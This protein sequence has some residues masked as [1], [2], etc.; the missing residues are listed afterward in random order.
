MGVAFDLEALLE[1][2]LQLP[3]QQKLELMAYLMISMGLVAFT[4]LM[5]LSAPYGRYAPANTWLWGPNINGKVAWVLQEAPCLVMTIYCLLHADPSLMA[6]WPNR[7]LVGL[8]AIHYINRTLIFPMRIKGGKPTPLSV[9]LLAFIFC[10]Y[11]GY[12]QMAYQTQIATYQDD[13]LTDPRFV[14]GVVMFGAGMAINIQA[15]N[16]LLNLRKPGETGYK[17]PR[18]GMFEFVSG[19]NF[20]GEIVEWTGFAIASWSLMGAAFAIFTFCNIGPR[21]MQHHKW[22]L[23]KFKEEYPKSRFAVIPFLW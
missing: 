4:L 7:I 17:I 13:W 14:F 16:I 8:Y 20:F 5:W 9:F 22:Y 6:S 19:A 1:Q 2:F 23:E 15:D 18:G 21:G 3:L 12:M 10:L 11:N